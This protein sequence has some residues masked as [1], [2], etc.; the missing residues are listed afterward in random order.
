MP[1]HVS[2]PVTHLSFEVW[3]GE[4]C[5]SSRSLQRGR[6]GRRAS[7][8]PWLWTAP[9]GTAAFWALCLG[10]TT[11][12]KLSEIEALPR[13]LCCYQQPD[14]VI[15]CV[16]MFFWL[17]LQNRFHSLPREHTKR[18]LTVTT[19]KPDWK[20]VCH[21][22]QPRRWPARSLQDFWQKGWGCKEQHYRVCLVRT[23]SFP[24][25]KCL[26]KQSERNLRLLSHLCVKRA[27]IQN[28]ITIV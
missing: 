22:S 13:S 11:V 1:V 6:K 3:S 2:L 19:L 20:L 5:V 8:F 16:S 25:N 24:I 27:E 21:E 18:L 7:F 28:V 17:I 14:V 12:L 23:L 26:S 4:L 10:D 9:L 15:D